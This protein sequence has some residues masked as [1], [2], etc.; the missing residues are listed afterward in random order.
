[1]MDRFIPI[2]FRCRLAAFL[3]MDFLG[4]L[5][6]TMSLFGSSDG[7][8][9]VHRQEVKRSATA[10]SPVHSL[11]PASWPETTA[12]PLFLRSR[13][14]FRLETRAAPEAVRTAPAAARPWNSRV[15]VKGIVFADG[16]RLAYITDGGAQG[17]WFGEGDLVDGW[18]LF[19]ISPNVA[20]LGRGEERI[21][22]YL[23]EGRLPR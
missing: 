15:A 20:M 19:S 18:N 5:A 3:L 21:E 4:A 10:T 8:R 17:D 22:L 11:S 23:Y 6:V 12:R 16:R 1:M 14:P 7:G 9:P 13:R 2:Q